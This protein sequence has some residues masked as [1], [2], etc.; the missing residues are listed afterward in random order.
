[1]AV[2]ETREHPGELSSFGRYRAGA[3]YFEQ[4]ALRAAID[5]AAASGTTVPE[6][7]REEYDRITRELVSPDCG[8]S[9]AC[10][11]ELYRDLLAYIEVYRTALCCQELG[12]GDVRTETG[13]LFRTEIGILLTELAGELPLADLTLEVH[14]L[15]AML[16]AIRE[17]EPART[18]GDHPVPGVPDPMTDSRILQRKK[19]Q[20]GVR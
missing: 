2:R 14:H 8:G 15:D 3:P 17:A 4:Y 7:L 12:M 6:K 10:R 20:A 9:R 18:P 1:M 13:P 16:A 19:G 11:E 5:A